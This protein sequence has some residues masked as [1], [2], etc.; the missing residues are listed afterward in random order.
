MSIT[1][2]VPMRRSRYSNGCVENEMTFPIMGQLPSNP[3]GNVFVPQT[4]AQ[5]DDFIVRSTN[6]VVAYFFCS[7]NSE[8]MAIYNRLA[9]SVYGST[10]QVV[11]VDSTH[12]PDVVCTYSWPDRPLP[13]VTRLYKTHLIR[14]MEGPFTLERLCLFVNSPSQWRNKGFYP[15]TNNG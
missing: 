15:Q 6:P 1:N 2:E 9:Q 7:D 5:F 14:I 12:L 13:L 8:Q 3:V 11:M 10:N 4:K